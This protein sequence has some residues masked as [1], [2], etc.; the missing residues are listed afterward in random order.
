MRGVDFYGPHADFGAK[1][2]AAGIGFAMRYT[3]GPGYGKNLY[4]AEARD[5]SRAGIRIGSNFEATADRMLTGRTAGIA[6]AR[7]GLGAARAAGMPKDRPIYFSADFDVVGSWQTSR[8][9]AYLDGAASVLG[10]A[11]VGVYGGRRIIEAA[12]AHDHAF[13]LWQTFAWS[14][15]Y[16]VPGVDLR[17][18]G[19]GTVGGV[20]VD[21]DSSLTDAG[22]WLVGEE[23]QMD[24]ATFNKLHAASHKV[25]P[26]ALEEV[27]D[28]AMGVRDWVDDLTEADPRRMEVKAKL[29]AVAA[30]AGGDH[31][32]KLPATTGPIA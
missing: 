29:K 23:E 19:G 15:G 16:W 17:Q 14:G 1:L 18:T 5:L 12:K 20:P 10:R 26:E 7:Q 31:S 21:F 28:M 13:W 27:G 3:V 9:L 4:Y 30:G 6:D 8:V 24:Q 2:K 22:L 25:A 32:H 11:G